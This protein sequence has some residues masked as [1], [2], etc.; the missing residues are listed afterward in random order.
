MHLFWYVYQYFYLLLL[1]LRYVIN[2]SNGTA[3]WNENFR[4]DSITFY[5]YCKCSKKK[6]PRA[7][8]L[9][10]IARNSK[11]FLSELLETSILHT[12]VFWSRLN[13]NRCIIH[14]HKFALNHC[15][16]KKFKIE[17]LALLDYIVVMNH[18]HAQHSFPHWKYQLLLIVKTSFKKVVCHIRSAIH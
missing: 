17:K 9:R 18:D 11:L 1:L 8:C 4:Q 14:L 5:I 12:K 6:T 2:F 10:H 13:N 15:F 3:I 7:Y 16:S